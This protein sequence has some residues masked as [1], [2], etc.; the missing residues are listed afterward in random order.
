MMIQT[1]NARRFPIFNPGFE[2]FL[3]LDDHYEFRGS[4]Y[5]RPIDPLAVGGNQ[6]STDLLALLKIL[7]SFPSRYYYIIEDDTYSCSTEH[8][9]LIMKHD[10]DPDRCLWTTGIG[11]TGFLFSHSVLLNLIELF[12]RSTAQPHPDTVVEHGYKHICVPRINLNAH[13]Y[14]GSVSGHGH[15][16][17]DRQYPSCFE[18]KCATRI[19]DHFPPECAGDFYLAAEGTCV[20][21]SDDENNPLFGGYYGRFCRTRSKDMVVEGRGLPQSVKALHE[22]LMT[23]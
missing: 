16:A 8:L 10:P 1:T 3:V 2:Q 15:G 5:P 23:L 11:A 7:I 21:V 20:Q 22:R 17:L 9:L 14:E 13:L 18:F 19:L 12:E 4:E 6:H